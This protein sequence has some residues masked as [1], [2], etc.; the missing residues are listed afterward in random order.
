[1]LGTGCR[2]LQHCAWAATYNTGHQLLLP[3]ALG[4]DCYCLVLV[5]IARCSSTG[6]YLPLSRWTVQGAAYT[7][8]G[9]GLS[10]VCHT[11]KVAVYRSHYNVAGSPCR[12]W[13]A[14]PLG[15]GALLFG[16]RNV[17]S[18]RVPCG[19][20]ARKPDW[21]WI[22]LR[23]T[24]VIPSSFHGGLP[25]TAGRWALTDFIVGCGL[26]ALKGVGSHALAS[27]KNMRQ[28]KTPTCL[29]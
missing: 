10:C 12:T 25:A 26:Y 3:T 29:N 16:E 21:G 28:A 22:T 15:P 1:M 6:S 13:G 2:W 9:G 17:F 11:C 5:A 4:T 7:R 23:S 19:G 20:G 8:G 27:A 18:E 14:T 24:A